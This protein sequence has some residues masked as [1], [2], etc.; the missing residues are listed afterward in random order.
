MVG[1]PNASKS[2]KAGIYMPLV[3]RREPQRSQQGAHLPIP[4]VLESYS[5]FVAF[6]FSTCSLQHVSLECE[7]FDMCFYR[8]C[9]PDFT[10]TL[11]C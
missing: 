8:Q 6:L 2:P 4:R 7:C 5:I 3:N 1:G 11:R 10:R 9:F